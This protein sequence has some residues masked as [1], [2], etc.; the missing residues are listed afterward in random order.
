[1]KKI[2][3]LLAIVVAIGFSALA[4]KRSLHSSPLTA[5]IPSAIVTDNNL[6]WSA[7]V[8]SAPGFKKLELS[9][10]GHPVMT[11]AQF[12]KD[13]TFDFVFSKINTLEDLQSETT[14]EG[15]VQFTKTG[16]GKNSFVTTATK[17]ICKEILKGASMKYSL[18][19]TELNT[20]YSGA[21]LWEKIC[22]PNIPA[23]DFLLLVN[24]KAHPAAANGTTGS[25]DRSWVSKFYIR[26]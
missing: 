21:W 17:G 5:D 25:I 23:E 9:A 18:P 14:V 6:Y 1:M 8:T 16:N 2:I 22:L 4:V 10:N 13:G 24:L 11:K 3:L 20:R 26:K 12:R 15:K 19:A 7:S